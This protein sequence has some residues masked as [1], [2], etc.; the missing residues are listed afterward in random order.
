MRLG[1]LDVIAPSIPD[2][3]YSEAEAFGSAVWLWMH[4]KEHRE[5]PLHTLSALLLPALKNRQFVLAS[6][7]G[8]PV[9]YLSWANLS[10]EAEGRY[11]RNPAVCMPVDDWASGDRMW[12]LDWIAPFGHSHAMSRLVTR[13][14][15]AGRCMRALYHR[16]NEKGIRIKTFHGIAVM[17]EEAR[18]WF[19]AHPVVLNLSK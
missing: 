15:F 8:K 2:S 13:R 10:K 6:E 18:Y 4:S 1:T 14:L 11:L 5:A 3:E 16:G 9:F 19:D 12:I 7:N 17:R